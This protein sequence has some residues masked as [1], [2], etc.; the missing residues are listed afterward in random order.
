MLRAWLSCLLTRRAHHRSSRFTSRNIRIT[1]AG[2]VTFGR[3]P[4]VLFLLGEHSSLLKNFRTMTLRGVVTAGQ[5]ASMGEAYNF[6][7]AALSIAYAASNMAPPYP[8]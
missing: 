3:L 8:L 7:L 6:C 1:A 4:A 2:I 5:Q